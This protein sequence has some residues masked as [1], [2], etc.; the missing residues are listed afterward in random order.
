MDDISM[1]T[2]KTSPKNFLGLGSV[3]L[4]GA[5]GPQNQSLGVLGPI[6]SWTPLESLTPKNFLGGLDS[7]H[8]YIIN[9]LDG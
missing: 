9:E 2:T 1:W 8:R 7:P 3:I 6:W 4:Y 5:Q